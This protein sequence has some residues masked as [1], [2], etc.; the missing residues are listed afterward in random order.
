MLQRHAFQIFHHNECPAIFFADFVDRADVRMIQRGSC[1]GFT[2]KT[3]ECLVV[4]GYFIGQEFQGDKPVQ[5]Q[6]F[7][8]VDNPHT[9]AAEFL[10]DAIVR[11]GLADQRIVCC[12]RGAHLRLC[13]QGKSTN[14]D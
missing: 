11:N 4:E 8:F 3:L 7:R 5:A 13:S 10:D 12:A 2:T 14:P 9:A 6:I 1:L